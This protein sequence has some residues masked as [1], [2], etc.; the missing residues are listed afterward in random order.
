M[1]CFVALD[2]DGATSALLSTAGFRNWWREQAK[3]REFTIEAVSRRQ[4]QK[5]VQKKILRLKLFDHEKQH[6][7]VVPRSR[8]S[9]VE[10]K[11]ALG[12]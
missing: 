8:E 12:L 2:L 7:C 3:I 10:V 4:H 9:V 6:S 1:I 5:D 11:L